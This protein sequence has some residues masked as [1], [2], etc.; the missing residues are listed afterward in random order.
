MKMLDPGGD[1]T[2]SEIAVKAGE[3][4]QFVYDPDVSETELVIDLSSV[5]GSPWR[6]TVPHYWFTDFDD[7]PTWEKVVAMLH[8]HGLKF[9]A[10]IDNYADHGMEI[11]S[12]IAL[13]FHPGSAADEAALLDDVDAK[14]EEDAAQAI[15]LMN[16]RWLALSPV[17]AFEEWMVYITALPKV[18]PTDIRELLR[19]SLDTV[20]MLKDLVS[21][22]IETALDGS[23]ELEW[24][25]T[26]TFVENLIKELQETLNGE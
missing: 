12:V 7:L 16:D 20:E 21:D 1:W 22:R 9:S 2:D 8:E 17:H 18:Y 3:V 4:V 23:D 10:E 19:D 26:Y 6:W 24:T 13:N 5:E 25:E 15:D 11:T 14:A